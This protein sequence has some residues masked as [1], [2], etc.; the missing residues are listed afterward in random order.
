MR[1]YGSF[2]KAEKQEDGTI[3][4]SGIA[5]SEDVDNDGEVVKA[6]AIR[7]AIPDYMKFGAVREMH[8]PKAAGTA[9]DIE[10]RDDNK[11]YFKAHVVD[12]EA[13]KKV[14]NGVYKGFSIGGKVKD[15]DTIDKSVITGIALTEIS[16][17]DRPANPGAVFEMWKG[18]GIAPEAL[19]GEPPASE[20]PVETGKEGTDGDKQDDKKADEGKAAETGTGE[21]PA[22]EGE[23]NA[24][25]PAP[26]D[27]A[28]EAEK[29]A[30]TGELKK[31]L[32]DVRTFAGILQDICYL[33]QN[34][35][36]EAEYEKDG[37]PVPGKLKAWLADGIGLITEMLGEE[38]A[39]LLA[40]AKDSAATIIELNAKADDLK[41]AG[42]RNSAKDYG[43]I[44]NICDM[45]V[46]LGAVCP[47][48]EAAAGG[49]D[50]LKKVAALEADNVAKA[51]T[52]DTLEKRVKELEA[53]PKPP[54]AALKVV[55][56]AADVMDVQ[57]AADPELEPNEK[58][59]P[60]QKA[61]KEVKKALRT[62]MK[63]VI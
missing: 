14:Q 5:S 55:D 23:A 8:Q 12:A 56:K 39:E 6:D 62:P 9:L 30:A 43:M 49:N 42:A 27:P 35:A 45:A 54:K 37:S 2:T 25:D 63:K 13:V 7:A 51:A 19:A 4:V 53:Q 28:G 16:L 1:I 11:T 18:D 50:D 57:K 26:A 29:S 22:V 38:A 47:T 31:S 60:E 34:T 20:T 46:Q 61:L 40:S 17:V 52:I 58:D 48:K 3:I 59:T 21:K 44:Q 33:Q 41:K 32:Y 36:W 10:V 24:A 15:R